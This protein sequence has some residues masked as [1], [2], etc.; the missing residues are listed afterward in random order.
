MWNNFYK[1]RKWRILQCLLNKYKK[2]PY[3]QLN[4]SS[5]LLS[6][7]ILILGC[8]YPNEVRYIP[9]CMIPMRGTKRW[10]FQR[11]NLL[12]YGFNR[13]RINKVKYCAIASAQINT[14]SAKNNKNKVHLAKRN[15]QIKYITFKKNTLYLNKLI[16]WMTEIRL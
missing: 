10:Q 13:D 16:T 5:G 9:L 3:S 8:N 14:W 15:I 7:V 1:D 11:F 2:P 4:A 12:R 6:E